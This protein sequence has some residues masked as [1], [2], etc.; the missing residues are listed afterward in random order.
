[1][2]EV[3]RYIWVWHVNA[4]MG[5]LYFLET[6]AAALLGIAAVAYLWHVEWRERVIHRPPARRQL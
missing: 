4:F 1:M 6:N 3:L 2:L 5:A